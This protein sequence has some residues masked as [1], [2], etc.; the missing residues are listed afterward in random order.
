MSN[1][2]IDNVTIAQALAQV[3]MEVFTKMLKAKKGPVNLHYPDVFTGGCDDQFLYVKRGDEEFIYC[4]GEGYES[5]GEGECFS[6][7]KFMDEHRIAIEEHE[8]E[9]LKMALEENNKTLAELKKEHRK[10]CE[11][12]YTFTCKNWR[13]PKRPRHY[14]IPE[15]YAILRETGKIATLKNI[16]TMNN[17]HDQFYIISRVDNTVYKTTWCMNLEEFEEEINN[18]LEL[19]DSINF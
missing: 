16:I 17:K 18:V 15:A 14:T 1:L 19:S 12:N 7:I 3:E 8:H 5:S 13:N 11:E 10:Y 2:K 6:Y 4:W 9:Q